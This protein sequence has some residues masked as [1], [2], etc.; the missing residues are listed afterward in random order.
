MGNSATK[1]L[2]A[3]AK[4]YFLVERIISPEIRVGVVGGG[5]QTQGIRVADGEIRRLRA[6]ESGANELK[7]MFG[8]DTKL[9]LY[10]CPT[11]A[12]P[13]QV[14]Y[15]LSIMDPLTDK[16]VSYTLGAKDPF[17]YPVTID[18]PINERIR[19]TF[20]PISLGDATKEID[21]IA[22]LFSGN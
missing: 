2:A 6:F 14:C 3:P 17:L 20:K 19:E 21:A 22:D 8:R 9:R 13:K 16:E 15:T 1:E 10:K 11:E 7:Y 18:W 5:E 4:P 12:A